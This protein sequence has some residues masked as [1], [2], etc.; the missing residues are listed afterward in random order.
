MSN[1]LSIKIRI[2]L[3]LKVILFKN[4]SVGFHAVTKDLF[5]SFHSWKMSVENIDNGQVLE[6]LREIEEAAEEVL[7][8]K[9]EI[10]DLDRKRCQNREAIRA[11]SHLNEEEIGLLQQQNTVTKIT[12]FP[13][14]LIVTR[15]KLL[16][17]VG[18]LISLIRKVSLETVRLCL[19][20][21]PFRN[22]ALE[23]SR[24]C[25]FNL[26]LKCI[27]SIN[28]LC[29]F[30]LCT[31]CCYLSGKNNY[32]VI[33]NFSRCCFLIQFKLRTKIRQKLGSTILRALES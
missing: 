32:A 3:S 20:S 21:R 25:L 6:H 14:N 12:R 7:S 28:S 30:Q 18:K 17:R 1:T 27:V 19:C 33:N 29:W 15:W 11:L 8:D 26:E 31:R 5:Y 4:I 2:F 22:D 16:N 23:L 13:A 10:V 24:L 9:Q